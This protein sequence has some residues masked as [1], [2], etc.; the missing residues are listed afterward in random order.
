MS[1]YQ[2]VASFFFGGVGGIGFLV[3][4]GKKWLDGQVAVMLEKKRAGYSKELSGLQA[5][6]AQELETAR[7]RYAR[8]LEPI[9]AEIGRVVFVTNVHF[10]TEFDALKRTFE[11]AT[12]LKQ[13]FMGLR[14]LMEIGP[15][16][17]EEKQK[18]LAEKFL[19]CVDAF[20]VFISVYENLGPF[21]PKEIADKFVECAKA[22]NLEMNQIRTGGNKAFTFE[23]YEQAIRNQDKFRAAYYQASELIRARIAK[24]TVIRG[25]P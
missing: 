6:Y 1:A 23:W 21:Y 3:I 13:L 2:Y 25:R 11:A 20:N 7:A 12:Q 16:D 14:P 9:K 10:E 22:S 5:H 8:E 15:T 24:L 19:K 17:K 4:A 18:I